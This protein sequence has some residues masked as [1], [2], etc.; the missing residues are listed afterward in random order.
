MP[1]ITMCDDKKCGRRLSCHR[2]T[3]TPNDW[4]QAYFM[5]TPRKGNSCNY[6][7]DNKPYK[8]NENE[9]Q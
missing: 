2:F 7:W 3:A 9:K 5:K 1:D 4:V 6:F 8:Q